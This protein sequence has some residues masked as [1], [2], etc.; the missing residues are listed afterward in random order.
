MPWARELSSY[1]DSM[2]YIPFLILYIYKFER[3][4]SLF[5]KRSKCAFAVE[6]VEYLGDFISAKGVS[7]DPSKLQDIAQW[8]IPKSVKQLRGFLGLAGNYRRFVRNYG[9]I[10]RPLSLLLKKEGFMWSKEVEEA[11]KALKMA[12]G[13][14]L[15]LALPNFDKKFVVETDA[16]GHGIGVVFDAG[17]GTSMAKDILKKIRGQRPRPFKRSRA[18]KFKVVLKNLHF[19]L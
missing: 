19:F 2:M 5:A 1:D 18:F 3:G 12:L 9:V 8:P 6:K 10:A 13:S 15:L 11:F 4:N 7:I 14:A 16:C 17:Q